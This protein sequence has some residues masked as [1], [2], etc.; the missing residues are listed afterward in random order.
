MVTGPPALC[1]AEWRYHPLYRAGFSLRLGLC[2]VF[3][4]VQLELHHCLLW[5][6]GLVTQLAE[7]NFGYLAESLASAS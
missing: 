5:C 6:H 1:F 7:L 2:L 3:G 4:L